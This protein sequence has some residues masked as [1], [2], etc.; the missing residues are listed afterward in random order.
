MRFAKT[1]N[2]K[3][4]QALK[5]SNAAS[6]EQCV[7]RHDTLNDL[8]ARKLTKRYTK[9]SSTNPDTLVSP[10]QAYVRKVNATETF[11][12][13]QVDYTLTTLLKQKKVPHSSHVFVFRIAPNQ[14][15]RFHSP[16]SST[17]AEMHHIKGAYTSVQLMG[18]LPVLQENE[19]TV[20]KFKNGILLVAVGATCVG[21]IRMTVE[22]GAKVRHGDELG[23]FEFGGSCIVLIVPFPIRTRITAKESLIEV[24]ARLA[25][26]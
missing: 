11:H 5:C 9:P 24:G 14:Y 17:V 23:F 12:I 18:S 1:N 16:V 2:I 7:D 20:L 26:L 13:K 4:Q 3:W 8:F 6:L 15:H 22:K 19:R 21:S 10:A 25:E